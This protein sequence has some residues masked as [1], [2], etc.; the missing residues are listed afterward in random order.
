MPILTCK[1]VLFYSQ[2][3]EAAFFHFMS[4]I[5]AVKRVEGVGDAILLHVSSRPSQESL[6]DLRGLFR[7]YRISN[8]RQLEVFTN[9]PLKSK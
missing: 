7:R 5:K 1:R 4:S 9:P 8:P 6:R 2:A 3:D